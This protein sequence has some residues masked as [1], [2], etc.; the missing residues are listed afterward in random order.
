MIRVRLILLFAISISL[1]S[2]GIYKDVE[3]VGVDDVSVK[4]FSATAIIVEV[5]AVINN[6]NGFDIT[7]YDSDLD[8]IV[9]GTKLGKAKI[10][11]TIVLIKK[12]QN[13]YTFIVKAD[14]EGLS[15][16]MGLLFPILMTG[17][18]K[19]KV[20]GDIFAK[21]LGMKKKA[22]IEFAEEIAF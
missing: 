7:I 5:K 21:A 9:N 14:T 19:V 8:F 18:A 13:T 20:K 4:E 11:E 22:P 15:S 16:K 2:C 17:K 6:P 3:F 12:A 10:D 1:S